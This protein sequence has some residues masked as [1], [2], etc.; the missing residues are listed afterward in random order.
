MQ[1]R[2]KEEGTIL[3]DYSHSLPNKFKEGTT[4]I[5][6]SNLAAS[7][8]IRDIESISVIEQEFAPYTTRYWNTFSADSPVEILEDN[9]PRML[10]YLYGKQQTYGV[11]AIYNE[12]RFYDEN[13]NRDF[14]PAVLSHRIAPFGDTIAL[15]PINLQWHKRGGVNGLFGVYWSRTV[16]EIV[17]GT[18][19]ELTMKIDAK[20]WNDFNFKN[21]LYISEPIEVKGYWIVE[22]ISN[23]QPEN[24]K[25]CKV[26]LLHRAE[27]DKQTEPATVYEDI[28]LVGN[29]SVQSLATD[30]DML[31]TVQDA[32][33]DDINV[34]MQT[35]DK[36][37]TLT[38]LKA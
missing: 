16:T 5:S 8:N 12:F 34:L 33:G 6:T 3:A 13:S 38:T 2:N 20:F 32:N 30:F 35:T 17:E 25:L 15:P 21:I 10:N 22:K 4:R 31:M 28:P 7:Y 18:S 23:Y 9:K 24:S 27:Y 29:Q 1:E 26:K 14:I 36:N 19:T 37:G 11:G